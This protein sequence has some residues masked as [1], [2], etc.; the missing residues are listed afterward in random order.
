MRLLPLLAYAA[1][2]AVA[3]MLWGSQRGAILL[4]Y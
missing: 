3:V 4:S 2:G 1:V